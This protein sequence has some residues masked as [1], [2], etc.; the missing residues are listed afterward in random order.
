VLPPAASIE[1]GAIGDRHPIDQRWTIWHI[2]R[3]LLPRAI[4][5]GLNM[6]QLVVIAT[7]L[8][9][10]QSMSYS[11]DSRDCIKTKVPSA[12]VSSHL[13]SSVSRHYLRRKAVSIICSLS[14]SA[15]FFPLP[16]AAKE[17][18]TTD[19]DVPI[20][21]EATEALSSLLENWQK[22]TIDCTFADVPR[23]LLETKNKDKL[24]AKVEIA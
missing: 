20:L 13:V 11:L 7:I 17:Q 4:S 22:A 10:R 9:L 3:P 1:G 6:R 8:S 16:L 15:L 12:S 19:S 24:L 14:C 2:V 23:E 21:K 18:P 5:T